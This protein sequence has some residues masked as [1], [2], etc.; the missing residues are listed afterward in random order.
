MTPDDPGRTEGD[1]D[2][3]T[4]APGAEPGWGRGPALSPAQQQVI[5]LLGAGPDERPEFDPALRDELR[6]ILTEGL[7]PLVDALPDGEDLWISKYKLAGVHGCE[8]KF[9]SGETDPSQRFAWSVPSA[10]GT[11][12]H[13][14]I[15]LSIHWPAEPTPLELVDE[16]MAY[17]ASGTG[18]LADWLQAC[19]LAE[20]AE[21]RGEVNERVAKFLECFPP[22]KKEWRPVTES[23]IAVDLFGGRVVLQGRVDLTLGHAQGAT[24]RKV[25]IDLKTGGFS[26]QHVDDLRF[27]ALIETIRLGTP[28]RL[29]ATY[30]LDQGVPHPEPVTEGLLYAATQ[31]TIDGAHRMVALLHHDH[32][33]VKRPGSPCRWCPLLDTCPEG[34]AHLAGD[35]DLAAFETVDELD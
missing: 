33:P 6:R 18:S 28:P 1:P 10:R 31:R 14:A 23:R 8:A 15:E 27:Y 5:E 4:D 32:V 35:D 30:Y 21:L 29:L 7:E 3:V 9:V 11:I 24:A 26:G 22:L 2:G 20:Q 16:A 19:S 13:K 12:S 34:R 17:L 25:L